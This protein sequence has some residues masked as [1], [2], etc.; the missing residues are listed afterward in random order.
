M[1]TTTRGEENIRLPRYLVLSECRCG[2]VP[3]PKVCADPIQQYVHDLV[4]KGRLSDAEKL[5]SDWYGDD[6]RRSLPN[7]PFYAGWDEK[8]R[9]VVADRKEDVTLLIS[10]ARAWKKKHG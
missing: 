10:D 8:D 3:F 2:L 9:M 7:I 4:S 1:G 5:L 6:P